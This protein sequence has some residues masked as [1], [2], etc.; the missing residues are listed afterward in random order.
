MDQGLR[1]VLGTGVLLGGVVLALLFRQAPGDS[2][3]LVAGAD[4]PLV[5]RQRVVPPAVSPSPL[6]A[7]PA[8]P[9][10][11]FP[12]APPASTSG[13]DSMPTP[14]RLASS[15]PGLVPISGGNL[16]AVG[17]LGGVQPS[18]DLPHTHEIVDGDTLETIA[19]KYLGSADRAREIFEAN[20]STLSSPDVLPI[21]IELKI[22]PRR[23]TSTASVPASPAASP[24]AS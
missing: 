5:L 22:P 16:S 20:R 8:S 13:L 19:L 1:I 17:V 23:G 15:Y 2:A 9:S 21:G 10:T 18:D 14:P 4:D 6:P 3:S 24:A 11:N 12:A 7:P